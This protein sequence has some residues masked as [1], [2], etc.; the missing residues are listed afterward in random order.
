[1]REKKAGK[2]MVCIL[3]VHRDWKD[4]AHRQAYSQHSIYVLNEG[5]YGKRQSVALV[6]HHLIVLWAEDVI[7]WPSLL[8][9]FLLKG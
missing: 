1:M 7:P 6:Y 8:M 3:K 9:T 4:L 5:E 2:R